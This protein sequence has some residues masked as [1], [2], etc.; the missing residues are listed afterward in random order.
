MIVHDSLLSTKASQLIK[1]FLSDTEPLYILL[2]SGTDGLTL[3]FKQFSCHLKKN[4]AESMKI[5]VAN[6][7]WNCQETGQLART[8]CTR[9]SSKVLL[10]Y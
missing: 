3:S 6:L 9:D 10:H 2:T 4:Y 1:S 8:H 5:Q 7:A